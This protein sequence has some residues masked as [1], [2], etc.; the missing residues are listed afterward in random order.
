LNKQ[1]VVEGL[2][3]NYLHGVLAQHPH[4]CS[5]AHTK[6]NEPG[7]KLRAIYGVDFNSYCVGAYASHSFEP[8]LTRAPL[9]LRHDSGSEMDDLRTMSKL[10]HAGR[11]FLSFDYSDFNAQHATPSMKAVYNARIARALDSQSDPAALADT[12]QALTWLRDSLDDVTISAPGHAPRRTAGGLLSGMRDTTSLNTLLNYAYCKL[13]EDEVRLSGLAGSVPPWLVAQTTA[14]DFW[15]V[16]GDDVIMAFVSP[17]AARLW[18]DTALQLG[19]QANPAKCLIWQG[20]GEYLRR[21]FSPDMTVRGSAARALASWICGNWDQ[22]GLTRGN[23]LASIAAQANTLCR[24][25]LNGITA[26]CLAIH[27]AARFDDGL[28]G[29]MAAAS[30]ALRDPELTFGQPLPAFALDEGLKRLR[31]AGVANSVGP[32]PAAG[33]Q[34]E[35]TARTKQA[36]TEGTLGSRA[37][38]AWVNALAKELGLLDLAAH[39]PALAAAKR[40]AATDTWLR[41]LVADS[42]QLAADGAPV[43]PAGGKIPEAPHTLG[44]A[45]KLN[46]RRV[47]HWPIHY[48]RPTLTHFRQ[49]PKPTYSRGRASATT[50]RIAKTLLPKLSEK[51]VTRHLAYLG[52]ETDSS[53]GPVRLHLHPS[54]FGQAAIVADQVTLSGATPALAGEAGVR[55]LI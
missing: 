35:L 27:A 23:N 16:H 6:K 26:A 39:A 50:V 31:I 48:L 15:R 13:V 4:V 32:R 54:S 9:D 46:L 12:V 52:Y 47:S 19:F 37:A 1:Q 45:G 28:A 18:R 21:W 33:S 24:R 34:D 8:T 20:S 22:P 44:N 3:P 36:L 25:G 49:R 7:G 43:Q 51:Q 38:A 42:P 53:P 29:D 55:L 40:I 17:E 11:W 2:G 41:T 14:P 5:V 10:A 30:A